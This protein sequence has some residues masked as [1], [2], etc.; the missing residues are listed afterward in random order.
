MQ[1]EKYTT[2]KQTKEFNK[3]LKSND[4]ESVLN[5][6]NEQIIKII[7]YYK[8][9]FEMVYF[10]KYKVKLN[11][12]I[13]LLNNIK[14]D[15]LKYV[16]EQT[17]PDQFKYMFNKLYKLINL[18]I[19]KYIFKKIIL[20]Y[21][22]IDNFGS[23]EIKYILNN[24]EH[25][26]I[27]SRPSEIIEFYENTFSNGQRYEDRFIYIINYIYLLNQMKFLLL[28]L[29]DQDLIIVNNNNKYYKYIENLNIMEI[30]EKIYKKPFKNQKILFKYRREWYDY[31]DEFKEGY[32]CFKCVYIYENIN[33]YIYH[34]LLSTSLD[35]VALKIDLIDILINLEKSNHEDLRTPEDLAK[36]ESLKFYNDFKNDGEHFLKM[37]NFG[38]IENEFIKIEENY[39]FYNKIN[40]I[41][42][43]LPEGL[44]N[45][46]FLSYLEK[47]QFKKLNEI[48]FDEDEIEIIKSALKVLK[49][50][51]DEEETEET[52]EIE[53]DNEE[54][55]EDNEGINIPDYLDENA[56]I[57]DVDE[58]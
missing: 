18:I 13:E 49:I 5:F 14:I 37:D 48:K 22:N 47:I 55:E 52:E 27:F 36:C 21:L 20:K 34:N 58:L 12:N 35:C 32:H 57:Q 17:K 30:I 45:F 10:D 42:K 44:R 51:D 43:N 56:E 28:T 24:S 54:I 23:I 29:N 2:Q 6:I 26:K 38:N 40:E 39:E 46:N 33:L 50:D 53:E 3:I 8:K 41:S 9:Y 25:K 7:K 15:R 1:S 19:K 16:Q 4:A 31:E 11:D